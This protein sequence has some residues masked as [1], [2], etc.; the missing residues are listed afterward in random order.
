MLKEG[1]PAAG[2]NPL[3]GQNQNKASSHSIA[4]Y[5]RLVNE[6]F[7]YV[8]D[9]HGKEYRIWKRCKC[10]KISAA[11][12]K[13]LFELIDYVSRDRWTCPPCRREEA[14]VWRVFNRMELA[15]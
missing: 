5:P 3:T 10:G 12:G 7:A 1:R 2:C 11:M 9:A 4:E 15:A 6:T 8:I 14:G 13:E